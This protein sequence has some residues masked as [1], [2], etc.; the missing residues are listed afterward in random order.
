[1]KDMT[2]FDSWVGRFRNLL[3]VASLTSVVA[4]TTNAQWTQTDEPWIGSIRTIAVAESLFAGADE[5]LFVSSDGGEQWNMIE[6]PGWVINDLAI[7]GQVVAAGTQ[8]G[9]YYSFLPNLVWYVSWNGF[10]TT[11][12]VAS[13]DAL[14]AASTFGELLR[15]TNHGITWTQVDG[16]QLAGS[17][18]HLAANGSTVIAGGWDGINLSTDDGLTWSDISLPGNVLV[19]NLLVTDNVIVA[20]TY[21]DGIFRSTDDG[22]T[23]I[24]GNTGLSDTTVFSL[25]TD[26]EVIV[27][28]TDTGGVFLSS[29]NAASWNRISADWMYGIIVDLKYD[30]S[31]LLVGS[32]SGGIFITSDQGLNWSTSSEGITPLWVRAMAASTGSG[33]LIGGCCKGNGVFFSPDQGSSWYPSGLAGN[34]I[35]DLLFTPFGL[36]AAVSAGVYATSDNGISWSP[37]NGGLDIGSVQ[38]LLSV[39]DTLYAGTGGGVFRSIDHGVTWF[40]IGRPGGEGQVAFSLQSGDGYFYAGL[41]RVYMYEGDAGVYR[42]TGDSVWIR[43]GLAGLNVRSLVHTGG[44]LLAGVLDYEYGTSGGVYKSTDNGASWTRILFVDTEVLDRSGTT[45]FAGTSVGLFRSTD[46]GTLWEDV[47]AGQVTYVSRICFDDVRMYVASYGIMSRP[48]SELVSVGTDA[49]QYPVVPHISQNYPNPFNPT[50]TFSFS[51]PQSSIVNLTVFDLLGREV[52][53]IVNERLA[54]GSYTRQWDAIGLASGVYVYRLSAG[55]F[56]QT[57]KLLLIR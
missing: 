13:N 40:S 20:A 11:D 56:V 24:P 4:P 30:G 26:G 43:V 51:I 31:K 42:T 16:G 9:L 22:E 14:L 54:P 32:R 29:D 33:L 17:V 39:E 23:W 15:S 49:D 1:M 36:Y 38:T 47:G 48:L 50:T 10:V 53:T 12:L 8:F 35:R 7:S 37:M 44:V 34:D 2:S 57:R 18:Y 41:P 46:G 45:V 25:A 3:C 5:G 55:G 52:A 19:E 27:A 28:G 21:S 6:G